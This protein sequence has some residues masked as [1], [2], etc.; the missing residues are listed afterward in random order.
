MTIITING[1]TDEQNETIRDIIE[2]EYTANF[3]IRKA[4]V[5]R[6]KHIEK[7]CKDKI[8]R[9]EQCLLLRDLLNEFKLFKESEIHDV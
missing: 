3:R 1:L 8:I 2:N 9:Y 7:H 6:I 4:I 5:K